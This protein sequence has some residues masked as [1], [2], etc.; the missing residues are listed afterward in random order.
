MYGYNVLECNL[1]R[2]SHDM[3]D[4]FSNNSIALQ[5]GRCV[6]TGLVEP[7]KLLENDPVDQYLCDVCAGKILDDLMDGE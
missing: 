2:F 5:C 3:T 7:E 4:S 6:T 1:V